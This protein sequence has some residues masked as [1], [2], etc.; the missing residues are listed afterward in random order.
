MPGKYSVKLT[1]DGKSFIHSFTVKMDPRVKTSLKDMQQQ[2]DLSYRCYEERLKLLQAAEEIKV[3]SFSIKQKLLTANGNVALKLYEA[4]K[5]IAGFEMTV[6]GSKEISFAAVSA[7]L[8]AVFNILQAADVPA[9]S[10]AIIAANE[11]H[12]SFELLWNK[13]I[14]LVKKLQNVLSE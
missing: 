11:S 3:F 4:E 5:T 9:T 12:K 10:Q 2:H 8:A 14:T 13:W 1:V 6:P 7:G